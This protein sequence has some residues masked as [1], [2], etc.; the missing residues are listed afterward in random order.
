MAK[1]ILTNEKKEY[2][3]ERDE[4]AIMKMNKVYGVWQ[5]DI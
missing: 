5:V 1:K 2:N 3:V 4:K